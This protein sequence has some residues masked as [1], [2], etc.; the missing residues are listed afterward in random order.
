MFFRVTIPAYPD[1]AHFL[2]HPFSRFVLLLTPNSSIPHPSFFWVLLPFCCV[3]Y[4]L[5]LH[6][7]PFPF[8]PLSVGQITAVQLQTPLFPPGWIKALCP[9]DPSLHLI[10]TN[11]VPHTKS[12]VRGEVSKR[13][14]RTCPC[15]FFWCWPRPAT[16]GIK[17]FLYSLKDMLCRGAWANWAIH[18]KWHHRLVSVLA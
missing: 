6:L 13:T 15:S 16:T 3:P 14:G 7:L 1:R 18:S 10:Q 2:L 8:A 4:S 11:A 12:G 5:S 17:V 9:L